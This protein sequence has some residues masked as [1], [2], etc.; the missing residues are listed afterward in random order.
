MVHLDPGPF[1]YRMD[2]DLESIKSQKSGFRSGSKT[3]SGPLKS[4]YGSIG[5]I[6]RFGSTSGTLKTNVIWINRAEGL[7]NGALD[8]SALAQYIRPKSQPQ[9]E[10][11]GLDISLMQLKA[12][13]AWTTPGPRTYLTPNLCLQTSM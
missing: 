9:A 4:I 11:R 10:T 8:T 2:P 3:R 5:L 13:W 6:D 1:F 12:D 7:S